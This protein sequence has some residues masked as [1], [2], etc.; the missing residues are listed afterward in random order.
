MPAKWEV[1]ARHSKNILGFAVESVVE[2][3]VDLAN[4]KHPDEFV[5]DVRHVDTHQTKR[6]LSHHSLN[7]GDVVEPSMWSKEI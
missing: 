3:A 2:E 6:V 4:P 7:V 1:T 5:Y